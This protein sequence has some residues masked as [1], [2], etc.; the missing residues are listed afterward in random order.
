M[1]IRGQTRRQ[2]KNPGF[3]STSQGATCTLFQ[4]S[5]VVLARCRFQCPRPHSPIWRAEK[6]RALLR[7]VPSVLTALKPAG[8]S[9]DGPARPC[10]HYCFHQMP[11]RQF[12][13]PW[14]LDLIRAP[15]SIHTRRVCTEQT[16]GQPGQGWSTMV[17]LVTLNGLMRGNGFDARDQR[18]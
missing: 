14:R 13:K 7:A 2:L 12:G 1:G 4:G 10:A 9:A 15:L 6:N 16:G 8:T 17:Q 18:R 5:H 11:R 3:S